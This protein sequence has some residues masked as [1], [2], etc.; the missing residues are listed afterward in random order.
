MGID[1]LEKLHHTEEGRA[2]LRKWEL[3]L[4]AEGLSAE[5]KRPPRHHSLLPYE[6]VGCSQCIGVHTLEGD[7]IYTPAE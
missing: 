6:T 2:L 5:L 1:T 4:G 3:I 7:C